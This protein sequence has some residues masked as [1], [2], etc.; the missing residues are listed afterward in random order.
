ML[1]NLLSI[2]P[3]VAWSFAIV[4]AWIAGEFGA[5]WT[6]LPRIS[7]Y[8]LVGFVLASTQTGFLPS[9]EQSNILLFANI[10][11]G[12]VLFEMGY[13]VNL[14]WLRSNPCRIQYLCLVWLVW[15]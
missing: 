5:R 1:T 15:Y 9:A 2:T 3:D 10:A 14:R 12:L 11:F 7:I 8:G 13:R 6:G 4:L